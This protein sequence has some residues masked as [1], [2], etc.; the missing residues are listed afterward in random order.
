M[1]EFIQILQF[2]NNII[3]IANIDRYK[4][5]HSGY[6]VIVTSPINVLTLYVKIVIRILC[7]DREVSLIIK[8]N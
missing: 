7:S 6:E 5:C 3:H 2:V 1:E 8:N 4:W